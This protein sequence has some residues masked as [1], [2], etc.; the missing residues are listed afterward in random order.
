[1]TPSEPPDPGKQRAVFFDR[2]GT[3]N[4]DVGYPSNKAQVHFYPGAFEAVRVVNGLGLASVV[5]TYQSGVGRGYISE[6]ELRSIHSNIETVFSMNGARLNGIYYCPHF[7][8]PECSCRKPLPGLGLRAAE[9]LGLSLPGSYM[10]GDKEGDIEFAL[11][12]GAVPILVL[13]GYG[14]KT[15]AKLKELSLEP[16]LVAA[17]VL[18]AVKWIGEEERRRKAQPAQR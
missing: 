6:Q 5:V 9:E 8:P 15:S 13:T 17:N 10:I 4:R 14:R 1:M 3:L 18:D 7:N 16:A 2:D 12:I 11:N